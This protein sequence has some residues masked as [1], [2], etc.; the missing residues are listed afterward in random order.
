VALLAAG[1][2]R[3]DLV[4]GKNQGFVIGPQLEGAALQLRAK[5][6]YTWHGG[7]KFSVEGGIVYLGFG[8]LLA[9][10]S[11]WLPVLAYLLLQDCSDMG[12][13]GVGSQGKDSSGEGVGQGNYG[14]KGRLSGGK[15]GFH[16][17]CPGEGLGVT[18]ECSG[19]RA[20]CAGDVGE[21]TAIEIFIP[22]NLCIALQSVGLGKSKMTWTLSRRGATLAAEMWWPRKSSSE[23]ANTHFSRLRAR[24]LAARMANNVRR[25]V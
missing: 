1:G 21:E 3:R 20:E 9:E 25:W 10:K 14:D 24:P 22:R 19:E 13:G 17:R 18:W 8:E 15:S 4:E 11:Q 16:V 5:V 6:F 7:E 23:T 12:V 2:R